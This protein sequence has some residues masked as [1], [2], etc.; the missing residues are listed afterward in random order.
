MGRTYRRVEGRMIPDGEPYFYWTRDILPPIPPNYLDSVAF[1]YGSEDA[2]TEGRGFGGSGFICGVPIGKF[3]HAYY[4]VTNKHVAAGDHAGYARIT[5]LD[6]SEA[7]IPTPCKGWRFHPAGDDL[8]VFPVDLPSSSWSIPWNNFAAETSNLGPGD[9]IF[10]L[11]R[12]IRTDGTQ[13]DNPV[14][15]FGHVAMGGTEV[16]PNGRGE[17]QRSYLV[18]AL[19]LNGYSGSPV[20]AF[21]MQFQMDKKRGISLAYGPP[22]AS[23][24]IPSYPG[25]P[26][27]PLLLGIVWGHFPDKEEVRDRKGEPHPDGLYVQRN[28]GIACVVPAWKLRELLESE[29]LIEMRNEKK[30]ENEAAG[31]VVELD[32]ATGDETAGEFDRFEDLTGKLLKVPKKELDKK[33]EEER[34]GS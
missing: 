3:A 9:D 30:R 2:A 4:I 7:V 18:E 26:G 29:E 34:E 19:S 21:G 28:S 11:G 25:K 23:N 27:P 10:I 5:C 31:Q 13:S 24:P 20:I 8:A 1:L 16:V 12:F 33:R 22:G 32:S 15:R 17:G 14:A 6:G